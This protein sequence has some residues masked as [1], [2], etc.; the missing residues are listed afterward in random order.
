MLSTQRV[1]ALAIAPG[2]WPI[3]IPQSRVGVDAGV[4]MVEAGCVTLLTY[5]VNFPGPPG[6]RFLRTTGTILAFTDFRHR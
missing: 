2:E 6:G 1:D 3:L 4:V 5:K